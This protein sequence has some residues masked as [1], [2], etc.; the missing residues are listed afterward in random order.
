MRTSQK[1]IL[2]KSCPNASQ[3]LSKLYAILHKE[4]SLV[5]SC[6]TPH[7][8]LHDLTRISRHLRDFFNFHKNL[9]FSRKLLDKNSSFFDILKVKYNY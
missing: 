7:K 6:K 3:D 9:K 8:N 1:R 4:K 2:L 5:G